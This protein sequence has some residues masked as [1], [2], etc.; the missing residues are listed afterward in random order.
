MPLQLVSIDIFGNDFH[1]RD[2]HHAGKA[3][4]VSLQKRVTF[5]FF[6]TFLLTPLAFGWHVFGTEFSPLTNQFLS[7]D[8][9]NSKVTNY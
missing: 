4:V 6:H 5:Y 9:N 8:F 3:L 2:R 7:R 1:L